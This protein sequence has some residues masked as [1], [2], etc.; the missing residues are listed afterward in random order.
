METVLQIILEILF[1]AQIDIKKKRGRLLIKET[2]FIFIYFSLLL[3]LIKVD[4]EWNQQVADY[5]T[6]FSSVVQ[7][8]Y[9]NYSIL[10]N[11]S[12]F[13]LLIKLMRKFK[14]NKELLST[15]SGII[16]ETARINIP[17]ESMKEFIGELKICYKCPNES[18]DY[19]TIIL[20]SL[21]HMIKNKA[22]KEV[23]SFSGGSQSGIKVVSKK[24][25]PK[26]GYGFFGWIR[27]ERTKGQSQE[28]DIR[29]IFQLSAAKDKEIELSI[30]NNCLLYSVSDGKS[31]DSPYRIYFSQKKLDEDV[32]YFVELYHM[33]SESPKS[34][35]K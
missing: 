8:S 12:C 29:R 26:E 28:E 14:T 16:T 3:T 21:I 11:S 25:F 20:K 17:V 34:L 1:E 18:K 23:F 22:P 4:P 24:S 32:W 13:H 5:L 7:S 30:K 19:I 6:F 35:V 15:L 27:F 9:Y 33:N 2:Q 10:A 31:K